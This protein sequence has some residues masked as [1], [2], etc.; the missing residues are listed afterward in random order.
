MK[1]RCFAF[2]LAL[3]MVCTLLPV[4]A[5]ATGASL[6][7][8]QKTLTYTPGQYADVP[9]TN[10]FSENV[11]AA[12]EY[13]IM[14]GYGTTFG[15]SKDIT[16]LAS[17]IIACRLNCIY[18]YG[19]N[20]ITDTYTGS[21]QE[22][23]LQYAKDHGIFCDFDNVSKSATRAEFAAILSSALP[24][25]AL[26]SINTVED[27]AIPD[28]D[29]NVDHA[30]DIYRLYRAGIINGSDKK[31][32]FYPNSNITR[33]AACAIATRMCDTSLRK[34][35]YLKVPDS[36][37]LA[38]AEKA[39]ELEEEYYITWPNYLRERLINDYGFTSSQADYAINN[40]GIDWNFHA[41]M[42]LSGYVNSP[43]IFSKDEGRKALNEK[44][45]SLDSIEYAFSQTRAA[46]QTYDE[47]INDEKNGCTWVSIADLEKETKGVAVVSWG[48]I[49]FE[50]GMK[51]YVLTGVP[52]TLSDGVVHSLKYNNKTVRFKHDR[53]YKDGST[54]NSGFYLCR[55]DLATANI[56]G[57]SSTSEGTIKPPTTV[58]IYVTR[59]GSKYHY[60]STCNGG[61][62][63]L[64]TLAE[65]LA[66]GLTPCNKCVN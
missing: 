22:I 23:H 46:W 24:E 38:A 36:Q 4:S 65:A 51:E 1:K 14:Q 30:D 48:T 66:R 56:P 17:I 12:Y 3:C 44:G 2:I 64:S 47:I 32:T 26:A 16:R 25:A 62:Y 11:K 9:A 18:N 55:E 61:T 52:T 53:Y 45:F 6:D 63:Y 60:D 13:N 57:S 42:A 21:T 34:S 5:L 19:V 31:G 59:T 54:V 35:V 40:A 41:Y 58:Q 27:N 15:V 7:N 8:F 28:V 49:R 10:T 20:N 39:K 50:I 33:G 43:Y 37:E 29:I